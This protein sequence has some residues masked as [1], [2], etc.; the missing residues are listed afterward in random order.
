[1]HETRTL[2][3]NP[4]TKRARQSLRRFFA[5]MVGRWDGALSADTT[6]QNTDGLG[7]AIWVGY[8]LV[9]RE[10]TR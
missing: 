8:P 10:V 3:A 6:T 5:L 1:M 9:V 2:E 4:A 7:A